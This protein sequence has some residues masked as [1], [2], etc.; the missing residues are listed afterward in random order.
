MFQKQIRNVNY[1]ISIVAAS[2]TIVIVPTV[3]VS[4]NL[5][6]ARCLHLSNLLIITFSSF[7]KSDLF[8]LFIVGAEGYFYT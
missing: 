1:D 2:V 8:Y 5:F 4:F 7:L 3:T 6:S